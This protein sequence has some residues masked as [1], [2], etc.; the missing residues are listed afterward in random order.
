MEELQ[1][2][3]DIV[4]LGHEYDRAIAPFRIRK[5]DRV[6]LLTIQAH[7]GH[8]P[9]MFEKQ[10]HFNRKV[11]AFLRGHRLFPASAQT[12]RFAA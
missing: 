7:D 3:V 9:A 11:E 12:G 6:H 2:T 8:D 10:R 5:V 1:Q 4:P